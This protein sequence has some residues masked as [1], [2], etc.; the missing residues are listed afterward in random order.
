MTGLVILQDCLGARWLRFENPIKVYQTSNI[1]DVLPMI[2]DVE[3]RVNREGLFAAGFI[4]YEAAPAFD[5]ALLVKEPGSLPLIWLGLYARPQEHQ[6]FNSASNYALSDWEASV[7]W[8][9]YR[10]SIARVKEYIASG[11]TYQVNYTFRLRSAFSGDPWSLFQDLIK[12][13]RSD[14][15]AYI[16]IGS[17]VICSAS[18]ELFFRLNKN[19]LIS[20]PMKGTV[21][22][23]RT[24]AEDNEK[25][26]WLH[27]SEKNRAENVMIVDMIRN[28]LGR[29]SK[30]GS[31]EVTRLFDVERYPTLWQMTSTVK[32]KSD[33]SLVQIM[34]SLFPCASI[35]GAPKVRTMK[36]ISE[37]ETV[38]R[39][40]YTGCIGYFSPERQ[41]Q[42]NVA[43]RTVQID[44][45]IN[46]AE[47][48]IGGGIV[49]DSRT[50]S[51]YEECQTKARILFD[52]QPDFQLLE[53]LLW[54]P[55][56]GYFLIDEHLQRMADS[57]EYFGFQMNLGLIKQDLVEMAYYLPKIPHKVRLLLNRDG[58][59]TLE[60]LPIKPNAGQPKMVSLAL[61]PIDP[62]N[63]FL[64]HKTTHRGIYEEALAGQPASDDVLL[65]NN[66]GELTEAT[67]ANIVL[68]LHGELVTPPSD[69]GLLAGT[70]RAKLLADGE[71]REEVLMM[72]DLNYCDELYL[73]NSVRKWSRAQMAVLIG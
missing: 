6:H 11:D 25:A 19:E 66:R 51:E 39:G 1:G 70:Y 22:R 63:I 13:Q 16:D 38:P 29:V 60:T 34:Q 53:S 59:R 57:A 45:A 21:E 27:Y 52:K 41:S 4:T 30:I 48:G 42:F 49:W 61:K 64:Y 20:R 9:E 31:V 36:I 50:G 55:R 58:L 43:I 71:I 33:A 65:W 73:I 26:E 37:L 72:D 32:G 35:T 18:P 68:R 10:H 8:S 5:E 12:A 17:H 14:Y 40:I 62:E 23:G 24:L 47:Y 3:Q 2:A 44:M 28:D 69:S 46:Q 67:T 54:T 56:Q 7:S 15:A